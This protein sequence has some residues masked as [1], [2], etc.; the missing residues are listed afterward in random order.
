MSPNVT[1]PP[2]VGAAHAVTYPNHNALELFMGTQ[3]EGA[4]MENE[5][6]ALTVTCPHPHTH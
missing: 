5:R 2:D 1:V 6:Q 3:G 4:G